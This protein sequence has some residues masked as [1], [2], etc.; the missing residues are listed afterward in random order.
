MYDKNTRK[1]VFMYVCIA[2]SKG[3]KYGNHDITAAI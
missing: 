2:G 3:R 1:Y